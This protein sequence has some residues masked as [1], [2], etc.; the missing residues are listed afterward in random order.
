MSKKQTKKELNEKL[1]SSYEELRQL[2]VEILQISIY[3]LENKLDKKTAEELLYNLACRHIDLEKK[4]S[5][6]QRLIKENQL[7]K[8]N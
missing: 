8:T 4:I 6:L 3:Q 2:T 1:L 5:D 7:M